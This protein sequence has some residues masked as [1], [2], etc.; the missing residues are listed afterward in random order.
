LGRPLTAAG[1]AVLAACGGGGGDGPTNP[2]PEPVITIVRATPSG[3]A[4]TA[5]A[6]TALADPLVVLV[7]R[8]NVPLAGATVAWSTANGGSLA[9]SS[10]TTDAQGLAQSVWTLGPAAG[11]QNAQAASTGA[12]GS[13]VSFSATATGDGPAPRV[14]SVQNN[15]FSPAATT[16]TVGTTVEWRWSQGAVG[17]TVTSAPPPGFTDEPALRSAPFSHTF[18]FNQ[19]GTYVYFCSA[20]GTPTGGMRGTITVTP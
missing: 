11:T 6:G 15:L 18:T 3:D 13:P 14:I 19:P 8:D 9:P 12:Q 10:T 1:I 17:H 20:H 7:R 5:V 16:V 2:N 4:Q